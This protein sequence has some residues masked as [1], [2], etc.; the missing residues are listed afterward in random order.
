MNIDGD[1]LANGAHGIH[2][3]GAQDNLIGGTESGAG[4]LIAHNTLDG[5]SVTTAIGGATS[6]RNRISGNAIHSNGGL[7]IDLED[8]GITTNDALDADTGPNNLQNFPVVTLAEATGGSLIG[9]FNS[10]PSTIFRVEFFSNTA[11]DPFGNG[12]GQTFLG[13][14]DLIT[15]GNGD[16]DFA[17]MSPLPMTAGHF[18]SVTA[19]DPEG[20]TSEF[21]PALTIAPG[22]TFVDTDD[23][24]MSDDYELE[25]FGTITGGDPL[26]DQDFDGKS[27]LFEFISLTSSK[28]PNSRLEAEP[29]KDGTGFKVRIKTEIGRLY[30]LFASS[31]LLTFDPAGAE[32]AGTGGFITF[33]DTAPPNDRRFYQVQVRLAQQTP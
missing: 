15:D 3:E 4:N 6:L 22:F 2:L 19:T 13:H 29:S 26:L 12:E 25:N 14:I 21:G 30:R 24:G 1:P 23:D 5:V 16:A 20:N 11:A 10:A 9:A 27:N 32:I 28:D 8:N 33:T 31:D 17:L 7:G 18:V